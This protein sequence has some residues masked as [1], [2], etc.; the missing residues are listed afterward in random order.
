[1]FRRWLASLATIFI[2]MFYVLW[3]YLQ[4]K[5]CKTT[6]SSVNVDHLKIAID[7]LLIAHQMS[8][9]LGFAANFSLRSGWG[10]SYPETTGY[11]IPT[12]ISFVR[13][14]NYR[15]TDVL[16]ACHKSGEWLLSIQH[17]NGSFPGYNTNE[18][19]VFDTGQVVLGLCALY[20][21]SHDSR[22]LGAAMRAGNWL[23]SVQ[24]ENGS[25]VKYTYNKLPRAYS[26]FVDV[27][28]IK[29]A[30]LSGMSLYKEV[31]VRNLDWVISQQ[32]SNGW[33]RKSS[34][35]ED[36]KAV[37]H[38]IAYTLQGLLE[39]GFL[40]HDEKCIMSA[41][42]AAD[43]LLENS[44]RNILVGFYNHK[45]KPA[46]FSKCLTG[47]AQMGIVWHQLYSYT[48][49]RAYLISAQQTFDYLKSKQNI[50]AHDANL[51]GALMGSYPIWGAYMPFNYPNW[52]VKF[53]I[54]LGL[55]LKLNYE[56]ES[57]VGRSISEISN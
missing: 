51:R 14:S 50:T 29:L 49:D 26:A 54:D 2:G 1:M 55:L 56:S 24:E 36:D 37:L 46:S 30:N 28:L 12:L 23:W 44:A 34:F 33:Y 45:W 38:T 47:V 5:F 16:D 6:K 20:Q 27:P 7:W 52:G 57:S 39:S 42:K 9:R 10:M 3:S 32:L 22:Y 35:R 11:L 31:A 15:Q 21:L 17:L 40:L 53:F 18:P 8:G 4:R 48:Q 43:A 19:T 13:Q 25:W 41:K